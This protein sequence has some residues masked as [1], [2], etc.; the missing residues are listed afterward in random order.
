MTYNVSS[1][2]LNP[3]VLYSHSCYRTLTGNHMCSVKWCYFQWLT[4]ISRACHYSVLNIS[5]TVQDRHI[6]NGILIGAYIY[7]LC[8][9]VISN[10]FEWCSATATTQSI[11]GVWKSWASCWN[12]LC[13]LF[14][15]YS[16]ELHFS[17][18]LTSKI[19]FIKFH[20]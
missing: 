13:W 12:W 16:N 3:T 1:A 11:A 7:G 5:E 2:T 6:Y 9:A 15:C 4:Q 17:L 20:S 19:Y 8:S 18:H 10:D 14:L